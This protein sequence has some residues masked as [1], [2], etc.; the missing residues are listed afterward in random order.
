MPSKLVGGA[1]RSVDSKPGACILEQERK[2]DCNGGW[3]ELTES[4]VPKMTWRVNRGKGTHRNETE[5][6]DKTDETMLLSPR[7]TER[8]APPGLRKAGVG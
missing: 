7:K 2:G 4:N 6:C 1:D 5:E 3:K 8:K